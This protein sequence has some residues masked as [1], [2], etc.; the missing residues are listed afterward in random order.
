MPIVPSS[1]PH[2]W[3]A[4]TVGEVSHTGIAIAQE[5]LAGLGWSSV[6]V[7]GGRRNVLD[8]RRGNRTLELHVRVV[9]GLNYRFLLKRRFAPAEDR[10]VAYV[11]LAEGQAAQLFLIPS[12]VGNTRWAA[13]QP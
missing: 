1:K 8:A 4:L 10:L 11:R 5:R 12:R 13:R 9:R 2:A 7:G 3:S 6:L